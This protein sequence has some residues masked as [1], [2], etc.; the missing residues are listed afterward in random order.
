MTKNGIWSEEEIKFVLENY[1][2]MT[3]RQIGSALNRSLKSVEMKIRRLGLKVFVSKYAYDKCFFNLIDTE[4]KAYWLGFLYADGTV[5]KNEESR[6]YEV[7]IELKQSDFNHLKKFNKS[8]QGNIEVGKRSRERFNKINN[9][10]FIRVYCREMVED[11]IRH[12]CIPNKTF[13]IEFPNLEPSLIRHFLRGF[14]DGDGSIFR[15]NTSPHL[16]ANFTS[17]SLTFLNKIREI[18]YAEGV[19][20]YIISDRNHYQLGITSINSS[21]VFL[22]Y[23]YKDANIYLDRKY[24][25][26]K[27]NVTRLSS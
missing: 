25:M 2:K 22:D 11:L 21:L 20:S 16:Y 18:L 7:S 6:N 13:N 12:G 3:A 4:E 8:L 23:I 15:R 24:E 27:N 14:F 26:Y 10:A 17:A 9:M 19:T 5:V 1:K